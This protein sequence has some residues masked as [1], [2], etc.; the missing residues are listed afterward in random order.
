MM[1]MRVELRRI[2]KATRKLFVVDIENAVGTGKIDE[3]S[4][5]LVR[6]RI[7]R[8][9]KP[10]Y[11]DLTVIGVS[12]KNNLF[13]AHSWDGARVVL[14]EGHDGADLALEN[15]LTNESVETRFGEVVIISG[16]G[17]FASQAARLKSLG[18]RVTVDSRARQLST[19]LAFSCTSVRLAPEELAA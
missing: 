8:F 4:C 14:M 13:P 18:I 9:Y 2:D 6:S 7:E 3:E 5:K 11:S 15:V 16:D 1:N 17:L 10:G 19:V 12:H